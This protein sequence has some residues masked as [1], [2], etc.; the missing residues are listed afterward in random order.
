MFKLGIAYFVLTNVSFASVEITGRVDSQKFGTNIITSNG[1]FYTIESDSEAED[2]LYKNCEASSECK[3]T[4]EADIKGNITKILKATKVPN[5][6]A[7]NKMEENET[8][9]VSQEA[10]ADCNRAIS[11]VEQ[12]ICQSNE[13]RQLDKDL[14]VLYKIKMKSLSKKQKDEL[15]KSQKLWLKNKRNKCLN[16]KCLIKSYKSRLNEIK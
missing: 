12:I 13:V 11:E 4:V 3:L 1:D 15:K 5:S 6:Q 7:K 2:F 8:S 14:G 9:V 10:S 16:E